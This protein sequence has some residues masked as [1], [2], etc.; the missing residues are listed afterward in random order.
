MKVLQINAVYG[1]GSTGRIIEELDKALQVYGIESIIATTETTEQKDNIYIVGSRLG[2]KMHA[3]FS[4]LTGKQGYF[5]RHAT[6]KLLKWIDKEKP[7]IIHLHNL[8]ANYIHLGKLL[9]YIAKKDIATVVTLHDCWFFTGKCTYYTQQECFKWKTGCYKCPRLKIDNKSWF[10]DCTSIVWKDKKRLFSAVPRLGVIGVSD[11]ISNEGKASFLKEAKV[12]QK[13]Y[14]WIDLSVFYPRTEDI[15]DK[16]GIPKDKFLIFCISAGW[17]KN[18]ERFKDLMK[19]AKKLDNDTRI[20]LVGGISDEIELPSNIIPLGYVNSTDEL[21]KLYSQADV[22][23][24]L[25]HRDTF[26]KVIAEAMSCGT[27]AIVY[28]TTACPELIGEGCGYV[29]ETG[30]I[31]EV[32]NC[33]HKVKLSGKSNYSKKCTDFVKANFEKE[34]LIKATI[35]LYDRLSKE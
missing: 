12:I 21:A 10:F 18:A 6:R 28:N 7:D 9:K 2:R 5:S 19:L 33:I 14:N 30:N 35:E 17:D 26:G 31:E 29:V 3:L 11:W 27:P 34:Q 16:Y 4:R 24:H 22:Y 20:V 8:H 23:V 25:S 15:R 1:I 13:I 32:K